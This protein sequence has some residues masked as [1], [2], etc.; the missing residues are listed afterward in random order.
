MMPQE[1][2]ESSHD[3]N[4]QQ[5]PARY[6]S[7][8]RLSTS[9]ASPRRPGVRADFR[10]SGAFTNMRIGAGAVAV[11]RSDAEGVIRVEGVPPSHRG[12]D[13]RDTYALTGTL[14]TGPPN[15]A[16]AMFLSRTRRLADS[17]RGTM[18]L[19]RSERGPCAGDVSRDGCHA[20]KQQTTE[21]RNIVG[22]IGER[23][24]ARGEYS[25]T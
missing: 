10:A 6:Q 22:F 5:N 11:V 20:A 24:S 1:K 23:I 16:N 18:E 13:A 3:P 17:L 14:R 25:C 9:S 2:Y 15:P 19:R 12:Q 8:G 21:G 4:L 7:F